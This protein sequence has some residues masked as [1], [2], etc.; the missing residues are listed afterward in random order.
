MASVPD[1]VP[2]MEEG[3]QEMGN[4][5]LTTPFAK[6]GDLISTQRGPDS[7]LCSSSVE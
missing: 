5:W 3:S 6:K 7:V 1:D 2:T 4:A